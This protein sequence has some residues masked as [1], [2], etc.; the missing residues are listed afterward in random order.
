MRYL[1]ILLFTVSFLSYARAQHSFPFPKNIELVEL[2][3]YQMPPQQLIKQGKYLLIQMA[4]AKYQILNLEDTK[5][6]LWDQVQSVDLI[7]TKY[8]ADTSKWRTNY[9]ELMNGRLQALYGLDT[10]IFNNK[11]IKWRYVLQTACKTEPEAMQY[12]HGFLL[13]MEPG[14]PLTEEEE[15]EI[16]EEIVEKPVRKRPRY[17]QPSDS[18][19]DF[20]KDHPEM[21]EI[22]SIMYG[23]VNQLKDSSVFDVMKRHPEWKNMLVVMDWTASMYV[24]RASVMNWYRR[25]MNEE[26]IRHLVF[27]NDGNWTPH[28]GKKIGRTGG[29]YHARPYDYD[30]VLRLM[31][32]VRKN[33]LGGDPAE[34]DIEALLV[35]SRNLSGYR[36]IIFLPDRNTSIRDLKL[37]TRLKM[38]VRIILFRNKKVKQRAVGRNSGK[39][40]ANHYIHPHYLTLASFTGGSIHTDRRD[41]YDLQSYKAG[42]TI[43]FGKYKYQKQKNGTFRLISRG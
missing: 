41:V 17:L 37:L 27:F 43:S 20:L 29:I 3:V 30:K 31:Y 7:F 9:Q 28:G 14:R 22:A 1:F 39:L 34:N 35:S 6:A 26:V 2:P 11:E 19:P 40:V 36:E 16:K 12:F 15:G 24:N 13:R 4:Y 23:K 33:G 21:E 8:P 5:N 10:S 32:K 18:L 42:D 25:Q 38:P